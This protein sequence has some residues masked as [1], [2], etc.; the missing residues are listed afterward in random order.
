[1]SDKISF[2]VYVEKKSKHK[3]NEDQIRIQLRYIADAAARNESRG[4][5]GK[6]QRK[7]VE[8]SEIDNDPEDYKYLYKARIRLVATK[9]RSE[10]TANK[11]FEAAER[12]VQAAAS[13][14]EWTYVG[15][16][17]FVQEEGQAGALEAEGVNLDR[18]P[19]ALPDLTPEL[20]QKHFGN[21]YDREAHIRLIHDSARTHV[22]SGGEYRTHVL[23][24]GP[25]ASAKT[26][27]LHGFKEMFEGG[28]DHERVM[29]VDAT[30]TSKAGFEI[31]LMQMAQDGLLPEFVYI[32]EIEKQM[33]RV[34]AVFNCL[35]SI[36]DSRGTISRTNA[37]VG[38]ITRATPV[39]V[40][41]TS[42]DEDFIKHYDS[43]AIW[44]RF[45]RRIRCEAPS[46]DRV[47][48]IMTDKVLLYPEGKLEW[49]EPALILGWDILN[50]KDPREIIALALDGKDRLLTGEFQKDI[51]AVTEPYPKEK[52]EMD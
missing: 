28:K 34:P 13:A 19:F 43:G 18:P 40:W 45:Q 9:S 50:S 31:K 42:N 16:Q 26:T 39:T 46:R 49:V 10:E 36:M 52:V 20:I 51:L 11:A 38:S 48:Q 37:R 35:L 3:L 32:E 2:N 6:V 7:S 1:M 44:S 15:Q 41:A 24:Y 4:F 25:A 14:K 23:L 21:L 22:N 30:T 27:L 17:S 29:V 33:K 12:V 8:P 5:I 47:R